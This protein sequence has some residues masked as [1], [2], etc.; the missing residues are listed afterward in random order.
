MNWHKIYNECKSFVVI[1]SKWLGETSC[2]KSS[3]IAFD[4]TI[5]P[6]FILNTHLQEM[7]F[8]PLGSGT[9]DQVLLTIRESYYSCMAISHFFASLPF[10]TFS[11]IWGSFE[12]AMMAHSTSLVATHQSQ[13]HSLRCF[14][15]LFFHPSCYGLFKPSSYG[16]ANF[17]SEEEFDVDSSPSMSFDG[18]F[19]KDIRLASLTSSSSFTTSS[20]T[21]PTCFETLLSWTPSTFFVPSRNTTSQL[22]MILLP[23]THIKRYALVP[24]QYPKNT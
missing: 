18:L 8:L 15:G 24:S 5:N 10:K 21:C 9:K 14:L 11:T 22:L 1:D 12:K 17:S 4:F 7:G 2:H 6:S 23:F 3:L 16:G 13:G 20:R 19:F